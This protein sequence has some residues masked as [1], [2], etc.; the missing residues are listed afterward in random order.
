M[1]SRDSCPAGIP[2][3]TLSWRSWRSSPSSVRRR[4]VAGTPRHRGCSPR[5]H[6]SRDASRHEL[7]QDKVRRRDR[8]GTSHRRRTRRLGSA[9]RWRWRTR[10]WQGRCTSPSQSTRG[11]SR[12]RTM[13]QETH[14]LGKRVRLAVQGSPVQK[15]RPTRWPNRSPRTERETPLL[16]EEPETAV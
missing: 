16:W 11:R 1:L 8:F 6:R 12:C 7:L 2:S 4:A 5:R 15:R 10:H 3:R 14:P 13:R 9:G